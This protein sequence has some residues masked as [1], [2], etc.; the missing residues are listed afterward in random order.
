MSLHQSLFS[1]SLP[2]GHLDVQVWSFLPTWACLGKNWTNIGPTIVQIWFNLWKALHRNPKHGPFA[3][4]PQSNLQ[5]NQNKHALEKIQKIQR[6]RR[7]EIADFC[8]LLWSIVSWALLLFW[9]L[10]S[11]QKWSR[12][13]AQALHRP[14]LTH[15]AWIQSQNMGSVQEKKRAKHTHTHHAHTHTHTHTR[16][17]THTHLSSK[18]IHPDQSRVAF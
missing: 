3:W 11:T 5:N 13:P 1:R 6:R 16:T 17:H 8:P 4:G 14:F 2:S 18:D 7:P 10:F 15:Q 9:L 12:R